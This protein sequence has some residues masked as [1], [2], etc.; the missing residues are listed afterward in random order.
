MKPFRRHRAIA[1]DG[2]GIKGVVAARALSILES[3]LDVPSREIFSLAAGT[4]TGAILAAGIGV[5]LTGAAMH[6]LYACLG[7]EIF[8]RTWRAWLWPLSRYRYPHEPLERGLRVYLGDR[9]MGDF[10]D[11][12]APIDVVMTAFD[13]VENR[14]RFIKPWKEAYAS[15]PVV[16][17]VLASSSVPT[18]FPPVEG[19]YVDGG[20]GAYANPCYVAAY[21]ARF[22]LGWDPRDTTLISLGTGRGPHTLEPGEVR[23][24]WPWQWLQPVLGAFMQSADDQQVHLVDTFFEGL[25]FRRFQVD[26]Q[27]PIGMDDVSKIPELTAYGDELGRKILEDEVDEAMSIRAS[28]P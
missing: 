21:E 27:E 11:T 10:W 28:H 3:Y 12:Q 25:D 24:M 5:G 8:K 2:G 6:R 22:V 19:R 4:S 13:L 17:A 18:T 16:K 1:I 14:T 23:S 15:W 20:V 7:S 26:L 9:E